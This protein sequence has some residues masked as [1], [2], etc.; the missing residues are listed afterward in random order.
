MC[1]GA[2]T[3]ISMVHIAQ[4]KIFF[5]SRKFSIVEIAEHA[6]RRISQEL[7]MKTNKRFSITTRRSSSLMTLRQRNVLEAAPLRTERIR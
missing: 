3:C 1:W 7:R 5:G 6:N 2:C 4:I